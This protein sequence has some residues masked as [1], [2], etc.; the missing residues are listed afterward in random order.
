MG[1]KDCTL[2]SIYVFQSLSWYIMHAKYV[3]A[4]LRDQ[5][6]TDRFAGGDLQLLFARTLRL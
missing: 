4:L 1:E 2:F 6:L 3:G 5:I